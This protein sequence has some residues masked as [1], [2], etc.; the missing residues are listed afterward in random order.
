MAAIGKFPMITYRE[1]DVFS[2][3]DLIT[4][5]TE[6]LPSELKSIIWQVTKLMISCETEKI[7][8]L[9]LCPK[10]IVFKETYSNSNPIFLMVKDF[11]LGKEY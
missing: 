1:K 8:H 2:L 7:N 5:S 10:A 11:S 3:Q 9:R 6:L 4:N